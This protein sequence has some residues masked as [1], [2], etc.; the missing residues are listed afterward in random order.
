M[1]YPCPTCGFLVFSE[2]PGSYVICPVCGWEDDLSQLRF[3]HEGG[4]ANRLSLIEAQRAFHAAGESRIVG[5]RYLRDLLWRP[6]DLERDRPETAVSGVEYG[7][8]YPEDG[9]LLYYWRPTYWRVR[10]ITTR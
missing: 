5:A 3:P 4:G 7:N 9:T 6:L 10:Q 1:K 2:P 8:T